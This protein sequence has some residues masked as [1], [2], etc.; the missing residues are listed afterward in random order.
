M[1][2]DSSVQSFL[3][4]R[5][6]KQSP[7]PPPETISAFKKMSKESTGVIAMIDLL[8]SDLDK[9]MAQHESED[10]QAQQ[11]YEAAM[12]DSAAKRK[13]DLANM[14]DKKSAI[15]DMEGQR[16]K[17]KDDKRSNDKDLRAALDLEN[18]LH[19]ECDW[20]LKYFTVRKEARVSE[21]DAL[22]KAKAI[23]GGADF[24]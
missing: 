9:E 13:A 11:D 8:I 19:K 7:P 23:L 14:E 12:V 6:Q 16:Q 4:V 22:G 21:I 2:E 1:A 5:T 20:L 18:S 15:A 3:Q 24:S 10:K 17:Y